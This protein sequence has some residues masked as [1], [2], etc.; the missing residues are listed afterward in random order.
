MPWVINPKYTNLNQ[1]DFDESNPQPADYYIWQDPPSD[2][3]KWTDEDWKLSGRDKAQWY[4]VNTQN[5]SNPAGYTLADWLGLQEAPGTGG[6]ETWIKTIG[7]GK[8]MEQWTEQQWADYEYIRKRTAQ[9][10]GSKYTP[11][12]RT[13]YTPYGKLSE[14]EKLKVDLAK[15]LGLDYNPYPPAKSVE[16]KKNGPVEAP[17]QVQVKLSTNYLTKDATNP[18]SNT[19]KKWQWK[20]GTKK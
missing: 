12:D 19:G 7:N 16:G 18:S 8:P 2:M 20:S 4:A 14:A 3:T 10:T 9:K 1:N 11:I 13:Q 17:T 6:E 5:N 15:K